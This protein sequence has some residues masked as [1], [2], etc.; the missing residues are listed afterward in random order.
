MGFGFSV[1]K[2]NNTVKLIRKYVKERVKENQI[3]DGQLERLDTQLENKTID[4]DTYK[5]LRAVLEIN[6]IK[7][8]EEAL[9]KAFLK[10][11]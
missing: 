3:L 4:E 1:W 2:S 6:S 7:Q 5:R 8:R 11:K 9:E 10:S